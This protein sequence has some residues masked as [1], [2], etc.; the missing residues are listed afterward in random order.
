LKIKK[1]KKNNPI[2]R[3]ILKERPWPYN[4]RLAFF[5][6]NKKLYG[7]GWVVRE[8]VGG[9]REKGSKPCMHI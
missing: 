4:K 5:H 2:R 7:A 9:R 1:K 6:K 3:P 8:G